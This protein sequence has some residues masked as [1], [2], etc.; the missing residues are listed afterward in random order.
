MSTQ[1]TTPENR[2]NILPVDPSSPPE[3]AHKQRVE[4]R[5][6][7]GPFLEYLKNTCKRIEEEDKSARLNILGQQN[8]S[9]AYY[10]DR[11]YGKINDR[12]GEW[13][14]RPDD[15]KEFRPLDNRFK[16][17]V[18]KLEMEMARSYVQLLL[19]ST[20]LV[21]SAM[22]EAA[23]FAK[24]RIE[25]NRKRLF[26]QRPE[27]ILSE[28]K[29]LLL[30]TITYRYLYFDK[31]A[32]DG[33]KE[34]R[35]KF[36]KQ[37]IGEE[38]SV[39]VCAVCGMPRQD[40]AV[41]P[42][43]QFESS[44]DEPPT[45]CPHCGSTSTKTL[46]TTPVELELPAGEE[47]VPAG[48]VRC[49]HADPTMVQVSLNARNMDIRSTPF[50][51]WTQM[52]EQGKLERMFP[53]V[54]IP[55]GEDDTD[56]QAQ[57]RRDNEEA[58][59]NSSFTGSGDGV[60]KGG[61]QFRKRKFKLFWLD[62]WIYEDY[63]D[64]QPRKLIGKHELPAN[65]PL[66]QLFPRGMCIAVVDNTPLALYSEDK[67]KKWSVCV[68]GLR[69]H[70]F[71]GSGTNALIPLQK[72]HNDLLSYRQG[73]VYY[74]TAP[75]EFYRPDYIDSLPT[76]T[77]AVKV[78]QLDE[79]QRIVGNVYDKAPGSPLPPEVPAFSQEVMG[80]MQE[81]V[82]TSSLSLAGTSAQSQALG[83]ATGIAAMRDLAVGRIG[84]N[85]MLKAAM[86]VETAFQI[87]E[88]EQANYS[89]QQLMAFAGLKPGAQGNLGY[90][91]R[92]VEAFINCD[93]RA[94]FTI[95]PAQGS[96]MPE[97][98]QEKKGDAI[99]F[100]DAASRVQD[101]EIIAALAKTFKQPMSVGGF[102]A[103]QR[104]AA[105]RIEEFGKVVTLLESRG[106]VEATDEMAQVVLDSATDAQMSVEMEDHPAFQ[107]Y[108]RD[109]WISDEA[110]NASPLLRA[111]VRKRYLEHQDAMVQDAQR[112]KVNTLRTQ[113][114]DVV[115]QQKVAEAQGQQ[116]ME[117]QAQQAEQGME[118]Q[119]AQMTLE[120]EGAAAELER[121]AV[122]SELKAADR[123]HA[124]EAK[125]VDREHA[126]MVRQTP[127]AS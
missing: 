105:R 38:K 3:E 17:Q 2:V 109:W 72:L 16:E 85:L 115:A 74:N 65:T 125:I 50:L 79:G 106:Y 126:Q 44:S 34:R 19:E 4:R 113:I 20:D 26:T 28:N 59:S 114:P 30:K 68:Y 22:Q 10:D 118:Q 60:I 45:P 32:E 89:P 75:R 122:E 36:E 58:V 53:D 70:A 110:R 63:Q 119:A 39:N 7:Y 98:Q 48:L 29:S 51:V 92:G 93:I 62:R 116:Q 108:Y 46:A 49:V 73:N 81:Q 69:E 35:P 40:Y 107:D 66:G 1:I 55:S 64:T 91:K 104:E 103:T 77:K 31:Q 88:L 5:K 8:K 42:D 14:D 111:A 41:T 121:Q 123:E 54:L 120:Q 86:E 117:M 83:T 23:E 12:T 21:D 52:V 99:A 100:A 27:F 47:E 90:T 84:P 71:H 96:W 112:N 127:Q 25:A 37:S 18:D 82:G 80:A 124:L 43:G 61:E 24:S 9:Q 56:Q 97:T 102:N 94:S 13:E 76:L 11:Q 15:G 78:T 33:P 95:T 67:N 6:A 57:Y 87:L 101:P